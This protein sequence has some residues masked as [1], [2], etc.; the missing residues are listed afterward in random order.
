MMRSFHK[1]RLSVAAGLL[2]LTVAWSAEA[3]DWSVPHSWKW[4]LYVRA[5]QPDGTVKTGEPRPAVWTQTGELQLYGSTESYLHP[6]ID[7]RGNA[8]DPVVVPT[9]ATI[10]R[11]YNYG[12]DC[13]QAQFDCRV[14]F[15]TSDGRY[16][17]YGG[18]LDFAPAPST[19]NRQVSTQIRTQVQNAVNGTGD[20]SVTQGEA[21]STLVYFYTDTT[22]G[23]TVQWEHLH[24]GAYDTQNNYAL[25]D[26]VGLLEQNP[27]GQTGAT[28]ARSIVDD[29]PPTIRQLELID[30]STNGNAVTSGVCGP[31]TS[32]SQLTIAADIQD[33]FFTDLGYQ[34]FPGLG[35]L[36]PSTGIRS[37]RYLVRS[38]ATGSVV[39]QAQWF[40]LNPTPM[41]CS[42][43]TT[44]QTT[45]AC[46]VPGVNTD[47]NA[48][49]TQMD[50]ELGGPSA[51]MAVYPFLFDTNRSATQYWLTN[52]ETFWHNLTNAGGV[53]GS[54]NLAGL[55][56]GRYQVS[57][58]AQDFAGNLGAS[59][60]FVTVH[61]SG[62]TLDLTKPGFGDAYLRDNPN[63]TGAVPSTLGNAPFWESP[64]IL[65]VPSGTT[66][67]AST[68]AVQS[69]VTPNVP[70]DIYLRLN[71]NGCADIKGVKARVFSADPSAI[72]TDWHEIT[73]G[74]GAY[75]GD[76]LDTD[77]VTVSAGSQNVI[78]PFTW[79]PT[80]DDAS[81]GGHRC[82]LA[83]IDAPNEAGP[84]GDAVFDA[85]DS[86]QVA[87]RNL[88][89]SDCKF[90]LTNPVAAT[91]QLQLT[92]A[93]D[94]PLSNPATDVEVV[95]DLNNS[96]VSAWSGVPGISISLTSTT[97]SVRLH[98]TN[99][100]LPTVNLANGA[101]P[102]LA[103]DLTLPA[104]AMATA[105]AGVVLTT[106]SGTMTNGGSCTESGPP[107]PPK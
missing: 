81:H 103:F 6:G 95:M 15:K 102:S 52:G 64:D 8:G 54:W 89:V 37:A 74:S 59:S 96:W 66:V 25:Q 99:V 53:S 12:T 51:G 70:V 4:P 80:A 72:T 100:I 65:L 58:E 107:L 83:A 42:S 18:H 75:V 71:N 39:Q 98:V 68:P 61:A 9:D 84:T 76:A 41:F 63:D 28:L 49:F 32:A 40:D 24:I 48:F 29:E 33:T 55:P 23:A 20:T 16:L 78:G 86:N 85:K 26:T 7:I 93:T 105:R 2:S 91:T 50:H 67:T 11:V 34:S 101:A 46:V 17:Y 106:P 19:N 62:T 1:R 94:A 79:I 35:V 97:M 92:L 104:G 22:S 44:I 88:Q 90:S 38:L 73:T 45:R 5:D 69:L 57:A 31:E 87:Q 77:G 43:D 47:E 27:V 30:Q 10:E 13:L 21:L 14:W 82:L 56:N 60:M 3:T 36:T